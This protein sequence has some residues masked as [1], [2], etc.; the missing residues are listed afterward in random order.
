MQF[1][2]KVMS[3]FK[4]TVSS[5]YA[6]LWRYNI[7]VVYEL[8]SADGQRIEYRAEESTIAPVGSNLAA[9]PA[10][11]KQ[12]RTITMESNE[13]DYINLLVYIIPHTLPKTDIVADAKPFHLTIK[14]EADKA[15]LEN[16]VFDINQF[17]GDNI[18]IERIGAP[19]N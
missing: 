7:V 9:P 4:V 6:E 13:G 15:V 2:T 1:N 5:R 12:S 10:D 11:Y 3:R 17:S 16:R 18:A 8:C 14:V 19:I